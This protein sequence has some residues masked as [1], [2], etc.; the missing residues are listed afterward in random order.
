MRKYIS[1][2]IEVLTIHPSTSLLSTSGG[3]NMHIDPN[4]AQQIDA[5]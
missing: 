4:G 2:R 5:W 1:P 3:N